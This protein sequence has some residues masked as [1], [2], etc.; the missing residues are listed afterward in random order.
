MPKTP[1]RARVTGVVPP[2]VA[3]G[4]LVALLTAT[5]AGLWREPPTGRLALVAVLGMLPALVRA[6]GLRRG[7]AWSLASVVIVAV[8]SL[9]AAVGASP[10]D[11]VRADGETWSALG[12]VIPVGLGNAAA[13][14]LPLSVDRA[15][16]LGALLILVLVGA[17][18]LIAWQIIVARRPLA[19]VIATVTGLAYRWTLVP[20]LRP[21]LIGVVTLLTA[22]VAFRLATPRRGGG[23]GRA[24]VVGALIVGIALGGSVGADSAPASWW[25]WRSWTFGAGNGPKTLSLKQNY[26]PLIYPLEPV[27]VARVKSK[28]PIPLRAVG[29]ERFDG[30]SFVSSA[31]ETGR[32]NGSGALRFTPDASGTP[33]TVVAEVALEDARSSWVFVSGRPI[34]IRGLRRRNVTEFSDGSLRAEPALDG[35]TKYTLETDLPDPG[36][37]ALLAAPAYGQVNPELLTITPGAGADPITVPVWGPNGPTPQ[38]PDSFGQYRRMYELSRTIIGDTTRAYVAVNRIEQYLQNPR[39]VQY[40]ITAPR[41]IGTP[42]LV[43][44]LFE[45][46]RGYCQHFAGAMA[47]MLR[48]NGI[49]ARVAVGFTADRG[50]FD[51][52]KA[53]YEIIDRDAHSWVEVEFPGIGFLP[54]DPTQGRSVP[55][56][57]S[58]SSGDYSS[59]G[60]PVELKSEI[61]A[62]PVPTAPAPDRSGLEP[63][64]NETPVATTTDGGRDWLWALLAALVAIGLAVPLVAKSVR[65]RRRRRG[66]DR[67]QVLGAVREFESLLVDLGH[68]VDAAATPGERAQGTWRDL[69][70]DAK[71]IYGLAST[72]RFDPRPPGAGSGAEAWTELGRMRRSLGWRRRVRATLRTRSLWR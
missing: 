1:S 2:L 8:V 67:A 55:N 14:P 22:L 62:A 25:A 40:D 41:S 44:F 56:S 26:G 53:S 31:G 51:R 30:T 4:A 9:G 15:P 28:E 18:S 64:S 69:G 54:F 43:D 17:T 47:L 23:S 19:A 57:A 39:N 16:A 63:S 29:L 42:D 5:W 36:V 27:V 66:D 72:A 59:E 61:A 48:M 60:A 49:P 38:D 37:A 35:D 6:A 34:S 24:V 7:W 13:T 70:L 65:R 10:L 12:D 3:A 52:T 21:V 58:V 68:P 11:V 20:P 50:R 71:R 46:K 33:R 45:N 32:L